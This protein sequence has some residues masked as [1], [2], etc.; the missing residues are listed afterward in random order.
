MR[1]CKYCSTAFDDKNEICPGCGAKD[2]Y[3]VTESSD[4]QENPSAKRKW[5]ITFLTSIIR[6][7][8][9]VKAFLLAC[10]VVTCLLAAVNIHLLHSSHLSGNTVPVES[11]T[12]DLGFK[13]IGELATQAVYYTNVQITSDYRKLFNTNI[14]IPL[15]KNKYIYSYDGLIKAGLD[16]E[17]IE[18]EINHEAKTI[19]IKLPEPIIISNELDQNSFEIYD[20]TEN[21]FNPLQI[22]TLNEGQ[23]AAKEEAEQKAK[24]NGLYENALSN[25][26][27]LIDTVCNGFYPE[28]TVIYK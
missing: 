17:K 23:K 12:I 27:V 22:T 28:Y 10:I 15:T 20:E 26:K 19:T 3:V 25:A 16:F 4:N 21:I 24:K 18:Y 7:P 14:N 13:D 2:Y 1:I 6:A 11:V 5:I 8:K 9:T